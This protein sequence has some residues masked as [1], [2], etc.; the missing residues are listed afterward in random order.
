MTTTKKPRKP[1]IPP[2]GIP[3]LPP[4]PAPPLEQQEAAIAAELKRW[5]K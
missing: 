3:W 2:A 4:L 1:A 5:D